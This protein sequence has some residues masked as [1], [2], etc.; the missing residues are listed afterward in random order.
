MLFNAPRVARDLFRPQCVVT[1]RVPN[2]FVG[3]I[4]VGLAGIMDARHLIV[5]PKIIIVGVR[6]IVVGLPV[7]MDTR[8]LVVTPE[9]IVVCHGIPQEK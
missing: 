9:K 2:G 8:N 5:A 1:D 4:V 7:G 3:R 6:R